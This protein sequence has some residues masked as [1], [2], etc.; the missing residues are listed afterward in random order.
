MA[1][2]AAPTRSAE[3]RERQF[4]LIMACVI[5]V[6]TVAGFVLNVASGKAVPNPPLIFHIHALAYVG[7]LALFVAQSLFIVKNDVKTHRLLGIASLAWLP[8]MV[9]L[10]LAMTIASIRL[11]GGP[12]VLG[13][14]EFLWVNSTHAVSFAALSGVA[15]GMWRQTDWH[16][17]LLLVGLASI[18]APGIARLLP[19]PLFEPYVFPALFVAAMAFPAFALLVDWRRTGRVHP[20]WLWGIGVVFAAMLAGQALAATSWGMGVTKGLIAGTPG[21]ERPLGAYIPGPPP[22]A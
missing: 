18:G 19:L 9:I 15:I 6:L 2:I 4:F 17:R 7:W 14:S 16:R 8:L 13:V 12:P 1:T 20:A 3:Q 22:A 10:A 21:A 11:H 5:G